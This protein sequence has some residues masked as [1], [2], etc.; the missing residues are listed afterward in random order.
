MN[1]FFKNLQD[2]ARGRFRLSQSDKQA[3]RINLYQLME[4][5]LPVAEVPASGVGRAPHARVVSPYW[6]FS[7]KFAGPMAAILLVGLGGGTAYA[8][9]DALPGNPLYAVKVHVNENIQTAL[10][11]TPE[12]KAAVNTQLAQERLQEAE[13]L[14]AQGNLDA[15]T[16]LQL[17]Q[18]FDEHAAAAQTIA[19]NLASQDPDAAAQLNASLNSSLEAHDAILSE[20]S[21]SSTSTSTKEDSDALAIAVRSHEHGDEGIGVALSAVP[22]SAPAAGLRTFGAATLNN[23]SSSATSSATSTAASSHMSVAVAL[24]FQKN[25]SSTLTQAQS[26]YASI[27]STLDS[28]TAAQVTSALNTINA[29][30]SAG[31]QALASNNNS[32]AAANFEEAMTLSVRLDAFLKAGK[33]NKKL[34]PS[35]LN[36][37]NSGEG[38]G[39]GSHGSDQNSDGQNAAHAAQ[40]SAAS[41]QGTSSASINIETEVNDTEGDHDSGNSHSDIN[42]ATSTESSDGRSSASASVEI[43]GSSSSHIEIDQ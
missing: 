15:T 34:L 5:T 23:A 43:H 13:E 27:Q 4:E 14:A 24:K 22:A 21:A 17:A 11:T 38:K 10:A 25:A 30:M 1:N 26:D 33:W 8:A 6:W 39:K 40:P 41:E 35:L 7:P 36:L 9:Q 16:S 19:D 3:L 42:I 20:L 31:A 2:E 28:A 18:N 12:A 37:F 29:R 32:F